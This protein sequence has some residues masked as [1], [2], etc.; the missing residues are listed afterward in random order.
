MKKNKISLGNIFVYFV[1]V[2]FAVFLFFPVVYILSTSLKT[3]Q[4][5]FKDPTGFF[6]HFSLDNYIATFEM[7]FMRYFLNSFIV[8]AMAIVLLVILAT[9]ASYALVR[10]DF[11]INKYLMLLLLSGMMLPIHAALIPLFVLETSIGMYDTLIGLMLP[12]LAFAIPI[13]IFI[14]T[15]FIEGIPFSIIEAAKIDGANHFTI[16]SIIIAPLLRPAIVTIVIYNGVR[17]WNNFSFALIFTQS[18]YN[19]TIPLGLQEFYGEFSVN[20]PGILSAITISSLPILILYFAL[21][22]TIVKGLAGGAVKG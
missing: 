8:V 19:Y 11:K 9:M 16:F 12:Q 17:I 2:L 13:S 5:Y 21:Q 6:T 14:V 15:Q 10:L 7:G 1:E 22:E 18:Q 20:V 3:Q 4:N